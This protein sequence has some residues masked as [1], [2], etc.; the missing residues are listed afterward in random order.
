MAPV[1]GQ[2][3]A[4]KE[5]VLLADIVDN[6]GRTEKSMKS[7]AIIKGFEKS[8]DDRLKLQHVSFKG[9]VVVSKA[10][11]FSLRN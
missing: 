2:S 10:P 8:K 6:E 5:P 4:E 3:S 7:M 9:Y 11:L 1:P